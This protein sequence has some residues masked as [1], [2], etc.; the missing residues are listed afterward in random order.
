MPT[1]PIPPLPSPARFDP[2][3]VRGSLDLM[4]LSVLAAGPRYGLAVQHALRTA[5]GGRVEAGPG[6]LYPLLH[7]LEE[8]GLIAA[9]WS[10]V[11]PAGTPTAGTPGR[12][13]KWYAVTDAG[14]ARLTARAAD[15]YA[16][17][18]VLRGLL[19]GVADPAPVPGAA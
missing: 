5:S 3:L 17:A 9:E 15:W 12:R 16:F 13:R 14:T 11:D 10:S 19:D 1:D 4:V 18:E 2:D 6:T 8:D 7:R